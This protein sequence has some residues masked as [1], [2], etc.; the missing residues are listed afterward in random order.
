[1]GGLERYVWEFVFYLLSNKMTILRVVLW[2]DKYGITDQ[3]WGQL[4]VT[5]S[6]H[7]FCVC[8]VTAH[9]PMN[10]KQNFASENCIKGNNIFT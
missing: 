9:L 6:S 8:H 7:K 1:M 5:N 3:Q 4:G 10:N 2:E